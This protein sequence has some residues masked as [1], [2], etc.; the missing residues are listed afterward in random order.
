MTESKV[1]GVGR[2]GQEGRAQRAVCDWGQMTLR[3]WAVEARREGGTVGNITVPWI[4]E[5][6]TPRD[7]W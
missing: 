6:W 7:R 2:L 4:L 5:K 3:A 1:D